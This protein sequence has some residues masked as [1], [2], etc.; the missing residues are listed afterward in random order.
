MA[1][2]RMW[3]NITEESE[4]EVKQQWNKGETDVNDKDLH[5]INKGET[6]GSG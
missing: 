5:V 6:N 1:V 3:W 4:T 2:H